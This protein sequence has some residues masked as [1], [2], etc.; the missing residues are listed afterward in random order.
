MVENP[1]ILS[2]QNIWR[3]FLWLG[4][5]CAS[6]LKSE[7][8]FGITIVENPRFIDFFTINLLI[9]HILMMK[10]SRIGRHPDVR[11]ILNPVQDPAFFL[12]GQDL[13]C[14]FTGFILS[15]PVLYYFESGILS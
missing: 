3:F 10:Q 1:R 6:Y 13:S 8:R 2:F 4:T 5:L 12:P 11:K 9:L 14:I 15:C 7:F